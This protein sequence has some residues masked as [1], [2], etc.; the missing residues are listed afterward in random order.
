MTK[1]YNKQIKPIKFKE[2]SKYPEIIKD[3]AFVVENEVESEVIK[4]Q[5][6]KSGGRLLDN[7]DI[8][9]IYNNVEEGKKSIAYKLTFKDSSKTLSDEEV[10]EVFNKIIKEVEEKTTAK[11]RS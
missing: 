7:I 2:A 10:M 5:I 8:F 4:N 3:L 6:K 9:D 11:L 1:L